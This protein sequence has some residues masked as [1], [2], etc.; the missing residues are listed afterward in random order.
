MTLP[1]EADCIRMVPDIR[2]G[3]KYPNFEKYVKDLQHWLSTE[4]DDPPDLEWD[5]S[6]SGIGEQ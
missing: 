1:T 5:C 4:E 6:Q 3:D 2:M